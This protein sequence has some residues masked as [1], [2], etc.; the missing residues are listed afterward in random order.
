MRSLL[1]QATVVTGGIATQNR[2]TLGG[3]IVNE[4]PAAGAPPALLVYDAELEMDL[5][6]DDLIAPR[7]PGEPLR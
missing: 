7:N 6:D 1:A 5:P 3:N 2:G 4:C